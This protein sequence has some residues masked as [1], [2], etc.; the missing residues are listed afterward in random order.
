[1]KITIT[2][3]ASADDF[4]AFAAMIGD[5]VAWCRER[6]SGDS[7]FVDQALS[8][9]SLDAELQNLAQKYSPPAGRAFL[10]REGE[11]ICGCG[12]Y[13]WRG[14]DVVEMKR[15]FV[16]RQFAGKGFGRQICNALIASARADNCRVMLLDTANLLREAIALYDS[17]GFRRCDAY[18]DYP[19]E[20]MRYIIFMEL[21]LTPA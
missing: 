6:Y 8:H 4:A 1:L 20:L 3:A 18:N 15:L 14:E 21:P 16:P 2:P 12:A 17:L 5:Y 19:P 9:Q 11:K 7:W 10:A 13:R